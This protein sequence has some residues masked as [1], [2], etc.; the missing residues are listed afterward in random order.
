[1]AEEMKETN[2]PWPRSCAGFLTISAYYRTA[3]MPRRS[4]VR[5]Q[6]L[7]RFGTVVGQSLQYG[8]PLARRCAVSPSIFGGADHQ[9]GRAGP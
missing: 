9:A 2:P 7:R 1:M 8:T 6:G 4:W 5:S 3:V